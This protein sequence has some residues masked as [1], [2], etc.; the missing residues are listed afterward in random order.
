MKIKVLD[1]FGNEMIL[2]D[3][4][5]VLVKLPSENGFLEKKLST[6]GIEILSDRGEFH[7]K[8][9]NFDKGGLKTGLSQTFK[10]WVKTRTTDKEFTFDGG[11]SVTEN[12]G[13][14]EIVGE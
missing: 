9:S 10:M 5:E 2:K 4:R 14:K 11:L 6:H 8:L 7:V 1:A 13:T 12:N 3:I